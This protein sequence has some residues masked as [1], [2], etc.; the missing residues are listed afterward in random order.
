MKEDHMN[1]P[2]LWAQRE[3]QILI[4]ID[5]YEFLVQEQTILENIIYVKGTSNKQEY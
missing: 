5:L 4:T 2:I 3:K 1:A